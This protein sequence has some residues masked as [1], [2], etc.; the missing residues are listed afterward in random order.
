MPGSIITTPKE[1]T[2]FG[3]NV[4]AKKRS[5]L[6]QDSPQGGEVADSNLDIPTYSRNEGKNYA[7]PYGTSSN[8]Q[9]FWNEN[10]IMP[11]SLPPGRNNAD[12]FGNNVH[13]KR[14]GLSQEYPN[15]DGR[16]YTAPDGRGANVPALGNNIHS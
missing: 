4:H 8:M 14:T 15:E 1:S 13:A 3:N 2:V 16:Y 11:G 6:I 7:T 9:P 12:A 5:S 10:H